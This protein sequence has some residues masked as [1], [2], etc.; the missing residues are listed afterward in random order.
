MLYHRG[1]TNSSRDS[2]RRAVNHVYTIPFFKQQIDLPAALGEEY[3]ASPETRRLLGYKD[4]TA[5]SVEEYYASRKK[6]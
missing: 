1:G 6:E 4:R 2:P 5:R 3:S